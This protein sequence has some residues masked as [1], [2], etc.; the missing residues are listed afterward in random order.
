M[1]F[2]TNA[3][4]FKTIFGNVPT[5]A[6]PSKEDRPKAQFWLNVGYESEVTLEGE[7]KPRFISL[8]M[9]IPLDSMEL[10]KTNGQNANWLKQQHA[11]NDLLQQLLE[12]AATLAP[13]ETAVFT[14]QV[15][16]RHVAEELAPVDPSANEFVRKLF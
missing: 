5:A 6:G 10:A 8:P 9:G 15:E 2:Q 11:R 1:A 7:D 14:L 13:G 16:V 12:K 3:A 4:D